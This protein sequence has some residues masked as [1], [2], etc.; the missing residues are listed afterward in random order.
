MR[1]LPIT[2]P[3]STPTHD[4]DAK[5]RHGDPEGAPGMACDDASE[6][7]Q[8][9]S[10]GPGAGEQV[11]RML[12]AKQM[13]CHSRMVATS[14]IHGDQRSTVFLCMGIRRFLPYCWMGAPALRMAPMWPRS[15][16]TMSVNSWV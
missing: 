5:A 14:R 16:C 9:H 10:N 4:G 12:K 8:L 13:I 15:S 11:L 2:K 6:L 3:S 1:E 7:H